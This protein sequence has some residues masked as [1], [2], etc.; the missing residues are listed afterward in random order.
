MLVDSISDIIDDA[1]CIIEPAAGDGS[2]VDCLDDKNLYSFDIE[3]E[4]SSIKKADW[5]NVDKSMFQSYNNI[6]VIGN[7]PF[8]SQGVLAMKFIKESIFAD[9]I[10]FILPMSFKKHSIQNRIPLNF[11]LE[12]EIELP[13]NSFLLNGA[14]YH[15]PSVFQVWK[16]REN[17][18]DKVRLSTNSDYISFTNKE[19]ADFRVRRVGGNAGV[20]SKDLDYSEA[21]NY[22]M[23]N[24]SVIST[25]TV[26]DLINATNFPSREY[27]V[28][29]FSISKGEL[30]EETNEVFNEYLKGENNND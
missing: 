7:P 24:Q 4:S 17:N 20:A 22:F 11:W 10:A 14:E 30:V 3:P 21:S 15:A 2:F 12:R 23:K 25:D 19:S 28:G 9:R 18:R 13:R 6:L 5:F 8:G 29:P 27:T 26:I 1:D 16:K